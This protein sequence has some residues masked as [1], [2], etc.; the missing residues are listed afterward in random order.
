MFEV[1]VPGGIPAGVIE[2]VLEKL[3]LEPLKIFFGGIP[4]RFPVFLKEF[5]EERLKEFLGEPANCLKM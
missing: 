4:E 5:Q 1:E 2:E 3:L